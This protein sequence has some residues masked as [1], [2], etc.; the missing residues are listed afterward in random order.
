MPLFRLFLLALLAALV[1][2]HS[3]PSAA[4]E[5]VA[6]APVG[7]TQFR[8]AYVRALESNIEYCQQWLD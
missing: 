4:A 3:F 5:K 8:R 2:S 6:E 7:R 1:H